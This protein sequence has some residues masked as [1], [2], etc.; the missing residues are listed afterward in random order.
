M[1]TGV[2]E[3]LREALMMHSRPC[4]TGS[5]S[6]ARAALTRYGSLPELPYLPEGTQIAEP[7]L[8]AAQPREHYFQEPVRTG[9]VADTS[10]LSTMPGGRSRRLDQ[11][12]SGYHTV[13]WARR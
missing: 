1:G 10:T 6:A 12:A 4:L 13:C 9:R 2:L 7:G 3:Q 8:H 11:L 5:H